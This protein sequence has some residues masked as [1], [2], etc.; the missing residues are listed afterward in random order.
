[1]KKHRKI[2]A[3]LLAALMLV[4]I[5]PGIFTGLG[6]I[7]ASALS[8]SN[9]NEFADKITNTFFILSND[10]SNTE[11]AAFYQDLNSPN[12]HLSVDYIYADSINSALTDK[13]CSGKL[14]S[15][16]NVIIIG[17]L[18]SKTEVDDIKAD[19]R[20]DSKLYFTGTHNFYSNQ[21]DTTKINVLSAHQ[22]WID[23]YYAKIADLKQLNFHKPDSKPTPAAGL[24]L[25][26]YLQ[27]QISN[28][29][30]ADTSYAALDSKMD[31]KNQ[32]GIDEQLYNTIRK[33]VPERTSYPAIEN[34]PV[35]RLKEINKPELL[36]QYTQKSY[37]VFDQ[38]YNSNVSAGIFSMEQ[39]P[40]NT[41]ICYKA[42]YLD[43][44]VFSNKQVYSWNGSKWTKS[45]SGLRE[46][47]ALRV[48]TWSA[49]KWHE[50]IYRFTNHSGKANP[51]KTSEALNIKRDSTG[52]WYMSYK[53]NDKYFIAQLDKTLKVKY[54]VKVSALTD[55]Q[56]SDF[57]LLSN[58]KVLLE[59]YESAANYPYETMYN[60][61]LR[62]Y[63]N[64]QL[65]DL[66]AGRIT[67][68]YD[69]GYYP[70]GYV[71]INGNFIYM[72]DRSKEKII[73]I[74]SKSGKAI[75][76]IS[77]ADY[78]YLVSPYDYSKELGSQ[79]DYDYSISGKYLYL[80]KKSGIYR[81]DI[82]NGK[83]RKIMDNSYTPFGIQDMRFLDFEVKSSSTMYIMA[84]NFD[85][86]CATNFYTY[87][88]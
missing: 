68:E 37:D 66:N 23:M 35:L 27:Y 80:L 76:I 49:G 36:N 45:K 88:K 16:D 6:T 87:T 5:I 3:F 70:Y 11:V 8:A 62:L 4:F 15:A 46:E 26:V 33:F 65:L 57:H 24:A 42:L 41:P 81:I 51:L 50:K 13:S 53:S 47:Y 69:V 12:E 54:Q 72:R 10:L 64:L 34:I 63:H 56:Y 1:M 44:D 85:A 21:L 82:N 77:L 74:D 55:S 25:A 38:L 19:M 7:T 29:T 9:S 22:L 2:K 39:T 48:L 79:Y 40:E 14:A 86:E 67:K 52:N 28:N 18:P 17:L 78:D 71:K 43:A 73:V 83:F 59:T 60:D 20:A 84:V 32:K 58:G 61:S 31:L 75:K 30:C